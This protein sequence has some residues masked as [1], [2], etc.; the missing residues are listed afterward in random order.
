[1][2]RVL[3][4]IPTREGAELPVCPPA[5]NTS[6]RPGSDVIGERKT[7]IRIRGG[8]RRPVPVGDTRSR[9]RS[10]RSARGTTA[11]AVVFLA[12]LLAT[13][14]MPGD[15]AVDAREYSTTAGSAGSAGENGE[16]PAATGLTIWTGT[17]TTI[18]R[19]RPDERSSKPARTDDEFLRL[20]SIIP[21]T[22]TSVA[23]L[24]RQAHR[25]IGLMHF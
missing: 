25:L 11:F 14:T 12:A 15:R 9:P 22:V 1:M 3:A 16:R 23:E 20:L 10:L 6:H 21:A 7:M 24:S 5:A 8:A 19:G 13:A 17:S 4:L 18:R 2:G